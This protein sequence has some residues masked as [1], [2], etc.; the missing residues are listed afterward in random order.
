[1]TSS[2]R[3]ILHVD[4]DAFY[5]S[6]EQR[7]RPE[8]RKRPVVVG[9]TPSGRGV[10]AAASYEAREFGVHSAM[11]ASRAAR[12]CPQA[13]FVKPRMNVYAEVGSQVREILERYT[14]L[15]EPLSM[16]EAF[17]DVTGSR[18]LHGSAEEIGRKIKRSIADEL[19]L[20]ASVGVAPNKFLAKIASDLEK[21]DGFTVVD[22]E[23]IPAFLAP[24]PIRRLWGVGRKAEARLSAFG[25]ETIGQLRQ[26]PEQTLV[27]TFGENSGRHLARLCRGE[28]DRPVV[29]DH[30]A[31]SISHE[32][33]FA[34]DLSDREILRA[35]LQQL[36]DQ[37]A[38]RLRQQQARAGTIQLKVRYADFQ[39]YTRSL[40]LP[41]ATDATRELWE[42]VRSLFEERLP[43]RP[44]EIR[45]L[46]MGVSHLNRGEPRQKL[47]FEDSDRARDRQLDE[48]RDAIAEKFGREGVRPASQIEKP[49]DTRS[50]PYGQE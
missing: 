25:I 26:L 16:D 11:P 39:T 18:K 7:D 21:P 24:L 23:R 17:L 29:P 49:D 22:P 28:D 41:E 9:G 48:V 32:T 36:T 34:R 5:A 4:M 15:V 8:L 44:L 10:V 19:N 3:S 20:V 31:I 42:G 2:A 14:P 45:L 50:G 40:T 12:L 1:M 6:I 35:V 27:E 13:V 33:T 37:V 43:D 30:A 38:R 47:L 46:G